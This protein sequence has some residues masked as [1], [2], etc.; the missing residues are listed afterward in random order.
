MESII[1]FLQLFLPLLFSIYPISSSSYKLRTVSYFFILASI[2]LFL[3]GYISL[4]FEKGGTFAGMG[5][6][7]QM[8][9]AGIYFVVGVVLLIAHWIRKKE[10]T[11][12]S[13][14]SSLFIFLALMTILM[15]VF[16]ILTFTIF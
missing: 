4:Y 13:N 8:S 16:Q 1:F 12:K 10:T 5:E 7:L 3:V 11:E 2:I 14:Y 9:V 6:F 15:I